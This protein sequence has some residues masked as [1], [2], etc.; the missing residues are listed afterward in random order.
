MTEPFLKKYGGRIG[1]TGRASEKRLSNSMGGRLRPAS[2]A[3]DGAKGDF[4]VAGSLVEAKSTTGRSIALK[5]S[6]LAKIVKEAIAERRR[7]AV[8]ISF[9]TENG[10]PERDG[11]WVLIRMSDYKR[12]LAY[13]EADQ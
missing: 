1:V 11:D 4:T 13:L 5:Y 10:L 12:F 9:V 8:A 2:G 7:P 6:W 3:M